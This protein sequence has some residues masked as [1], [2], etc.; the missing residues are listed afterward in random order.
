MIIKNNFDFIKQSEN[1]IVMISC[2]SPS[3]N[4]IIETIN[5]LLYTERLKLYNNYKNQIKISDK[6]IIQNI[7]K[8]VFNINDIKNLEDPITYSITKNNYKSN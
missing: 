3:H 2:I 5:T 7:R 8:S 6:F 1:K 4:S